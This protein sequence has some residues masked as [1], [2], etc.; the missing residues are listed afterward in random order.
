MVAEKKR[1]PVS[2]EDDIAKGDG[3]LSGEERDADFSRL[4]E[5]VSV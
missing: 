1:I 5:A 4:E 2:S 3:A